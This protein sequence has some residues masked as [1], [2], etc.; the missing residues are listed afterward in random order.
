MTLEEAQALVDRGPY[1][2]WLGLKVVAVAEDAVEVRATWREDWVANP[3]LM[4]THGGILAA[5]IDFAADFA[6]IGRLGR[7]V[8]TIDMR[9]DY[10]RLAKPGDLTV[11]GR[12]IKFGR[13]FSV[14]EAQVLDAAGELVASGRGTYLSAPPPEKK[15]A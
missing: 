10:H 13:Q 9:V 8:P 4:Q 11:R 14:C 3:S 6:L 5:L 1:L 2:R 7:L 12:V 15:P